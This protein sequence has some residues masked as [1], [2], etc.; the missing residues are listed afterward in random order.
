M[1][2]HQINDNKACV[3]VSF[4]TVCGIS[5][6]LYIKFLCITEINECLVA[7][8]LL[9]NITKMNE[10]SNVARFVHTLIHMYVYLH[11]Y[12]YACS[13]TTYI[14]IIPY[15]YICSTDNYIHYIKIFV[16]HF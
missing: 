2:K 6:T 1:V 11:A 3:V 9:T 7:K 4:S 8:I 15:V 5:D 14:S 12:N 13:L 10:H 16:H